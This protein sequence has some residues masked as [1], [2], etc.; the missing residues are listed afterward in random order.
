M[1]L[2]PSTINSPRLLHTAKPNNDKKYSKKRQIQ[3][4]FLSLN[5]GH[6]T[7]QGILKSLLELDSFPG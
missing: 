4:I 2:E 1:K 3:M 5:P 7:I 6:G